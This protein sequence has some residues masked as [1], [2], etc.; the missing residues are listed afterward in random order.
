MKTFLMILSI[1]ILNSEALTAKEVKE[2]SF[3]GAFF[4]TN[5][6]GGGNYEIK[7]DKDNYVMIVKP[8]KSENSCVFSIGKIT[9]PQHTRSMKGVV[10]SNRDSACSFIISDEENKQFWNSVELIDMS[11]VI[12]LNSKWEGKI[13]LNSKSTTTYGTLK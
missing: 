9:A 7:K 3:N 1:F 5:K 13:E 6:I 2:K 10:S 11:Y 4:I 12:G 8:D